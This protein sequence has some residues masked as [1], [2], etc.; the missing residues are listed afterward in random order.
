MKYDVQHTVAPLDHC[1]YLQRVS[2]PLPLTPTVWMHT[3]THKSHQ[4][5]PLFPKPFQCF[6]VSIKPYPWAKR[7]YWVW[8]LLACW[9][10]RSQGI[11]VWQTLSAAPSNRG[12]YRCVAQPEPE[13]LW[14]SSCP[15]SSSLTSEVTLGPSPG[16]SPWALSFP[17]A[18][19]L[20]CTQGNLCFSVI[21]CSKWQFPAPW[22]SGLSHPILNISAQMS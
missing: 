5:I 14:A 22:Q 18:R 21:W 11:W 6:H 8:P 7:A 9:H 1:N 20:T 16:C 13:G 12:D 2:L 10:W 3:A 15:S 4:I 19:I 17:R